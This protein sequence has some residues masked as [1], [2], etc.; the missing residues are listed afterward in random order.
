VTAQ[1]RKKIESS[2]LK[3]NAQERL[4]SE[5]VNIYVLTKSMG[6]K[7]MYNEVIIENPEQMKNLKR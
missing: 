3:D 5:L 7:L 1:F 2:G 6:W 4:M